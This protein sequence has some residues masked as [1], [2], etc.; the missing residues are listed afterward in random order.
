MSL[1]DLICLVMSMI[2][3]GLGLHVFFDRP[4]RKTL[5]AYDRCPHA[6]LHRVASDF[7]FDSDLYSCGACDATF[8]LPMVE[9]L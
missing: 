7:S 3:F 1:S 6:I 5:I 9:E 8:R 2:A 4:V